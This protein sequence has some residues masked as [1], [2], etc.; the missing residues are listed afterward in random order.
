[1]K[2]NIFCILKI[3]NILTKMNRNDIFNNINKIINEINI[4]NFVNK[5]KFS[6]H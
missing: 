3:Q 2:I 1:M 5:N 6:I 4:N